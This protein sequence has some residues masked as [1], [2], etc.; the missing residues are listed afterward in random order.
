[1]TEIQ[2]VD[3]TNIR[4]ILLASLIHRTSVSYRFNKKISSVV[5]VDGGLGP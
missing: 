1:M 5:K 3:T 2:K 4:K